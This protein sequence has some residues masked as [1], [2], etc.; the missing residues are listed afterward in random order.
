MHDSLSEIMAMVADKYPRTAGFSVQARFYKYKA[1]S[2]TIRIRERIIYIRISHYLKEAPVAILNAIGVIL[3]D[4]LF[5]VKTDPLLK[6]M[7]KLY[8][9]SLQITSVNTK[10]AISS[11]YKAEGKYYNLSEMFDVLNRVYF[12][13]RL[14][15]PIL[16]WS[17]NKSTTRLGFYDA[18][19]KLLVVSSVFDRWRVPAYMVNFI[20]YHEMLH[21]L[22][23]VRVLNGRRRVHTAEF[24]K[25][26]RAFPEYEKAQIWLKRKLWRYKF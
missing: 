6:K 5:R 17:L 7:Y 26:E 13:N 23:P 24:K 21:I 11:K 18:E 20:L 16:G 3:F 15:K 4:K 19:R 8:V 25:L 1:V 10:R 12:S 22:I 9:Y 2:H 14:E